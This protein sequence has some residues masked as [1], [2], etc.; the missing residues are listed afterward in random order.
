[1]TPRGCNLA[2]THAGFSVAVTRAGQVW[3]WGDG[4]HGCLGLGHVAHQRCL[5]PRPLAFFAPL[6]VRLRAGGVWVRRR[7]GGVMSLCCWGE[8]RRFRVWG[9]VGLRRRWRGCV[10]SLVVE[11]L[12]GCQGTTAD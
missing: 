3:V 10:M 5:F 2:V 7:E 9:L 8:K 1:M 12:L 6:K 11:V 4:A